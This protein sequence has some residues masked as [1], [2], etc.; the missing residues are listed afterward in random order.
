MMR[1][2]VHLRNVCGLLLMASFWSSCLQAQSVLLTDSTSNWIPAFSLQEANVHLPATGVTH[3][4][5]LRNAPMALERPNDEIQTPILRTDGALWRNPWIGSVPLNLIPASDVGVLTTYGQRLS[6]SSVRRQ[7]PK[8]VIELD[9]FERGQED[10]TLNLLYGQNVSESTHLEIAYST[11][12]EQGDYDGFQGEYSTLRSA[13]RWEIDSTQSLFLRYSTYSSKQTEAQTVQGYTPNRFSYNPLIE[14]PLYPFVRVEPLTR[15]LSLT[16]ARNPSQFLSTSLGLLR[17][18]H[19]GEIS[20]ISTVSGGRSLDWMNRRTQLYSQMIK[21][22][23]R[24]SVSGSLWLEH[25]SN[26]SNTIS[27]PEKNSWF[28]GLETEGSRRWTKRFRSSFRAQWMHSSANDAGTGEIRMDH[29]W[30]S[31]GNGFTL[32]IGQRSHEPSLLMK[33]G[34]L[35]VVANAPDWSHQQ[36]A[37]NAFLKPKTVTFIELT[38]TW[39]I[40]S[41]SL[42]GTMA[43]L[44]TKDEW[45][46]TS[47]GSWSNGPD[48]RSIQGSAMASVKT[49]DVTLRLGGY[50]MD[51]F[52]QQTGTMDANL[53]EANCM[54][55]MSKPSSRDLRVY[56]WGQ[57][58]LERPFFDQATYVKAGLTLRASPV[59]QAGWIWSPWLQQW[60]R[61]G[62]DLELPSTAT[63]DAYLSARL[64][65][66]MI[67]MRMDQ[68]SDQLWQAGTMDSYGLPKSGRRFIFGIRVLFKN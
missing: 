68:A 41:F 56:G 48:Y 34:E 50:A 64:R 28:T 27:F 47:Q 53:L 25:E 46:R 1:S 43:W 54:D 7:S 36:M 13:F 61:A 15:R 4:A 59:Q 45:L 57:V 6:L 35:S 55:C 44:R 24:G 8:P 26:E 5:M 62:N 33:Q 37:P 51:G 17:D 18:I 31:N 9:F 2:L 16:W 38:P 39:A 49:R 40:G 22:G 3:G 10:R 65:W 60:I 58:E 19:E 29:S 12:D 52:V 20:G 63:V 30:Q 23:S 21:Q 11:I 32:G 67:Y 66:M 42:E 14:S